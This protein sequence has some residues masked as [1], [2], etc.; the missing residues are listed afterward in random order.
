MI[1]LIFRIFLLL[2]LSLTALVTGA[3]TLTMHQQVRLVYGGEQASQN[4]N[5][6]LQ[7][8]AVNNG[9]NIYQLSLDVA[10]D[11][12]QSLSAISSDSLKI[13]FHFLNKKLSGS[14]AFR[15]FY[16][17]SLLMPDRLEIN[18][19]L[20]NGHQP[21]NVGDYWM[22]FDTGSIVIPKPFDSYLIF[23]VKIKKLDYSAQRLKKILAVTSLMNHYYGYD[24][25][26]QNLD[27]DISRRTGKLQPDVAD[28]FAS[29]QALIR[30]KGH[31]ARYDL[32]SK[33]HLETK[34][35][36]G[37]TVLFNKT[38]RLL[39]RMQSLTAQILRSKQDA[40]GKNREN[41]SRAFVDISI[42]ALSMA[43][44]YQ[45]YIA[46]SFNEF[47]ALADTNGFYQLGQIG[48][49]FDGSMLKGQ[50]TVSELICK[51]FIDAAA[52][53]NKQDNF[54]NALLLLDNA[55]LISDS[56]H[57]KLIEQWTCERQRAVEGMAVSY[58]KVAES[59]LLH[60]NDSIAE[61]YVLKAK[62][63]MNVYGKNDVGDPLPFFPEYGNQLFSLAR[64][65]IRQNRFDKA[66]YFLK[67]SSEAMPGN[68]TDDFK[69][70]CNT[71]VLHH[72]KV[73][74]G[75][76]Q[77]A[78]IYKAEI[79]L[80]KCRTVLDAF[81]DFYAN[82]DKIKQEVFK[83][84]DELYAGFLRAGDNSFKMKHVYAAAG[85]LF[86][87]DKLRKQFPGLPAE[88]WNEMANKS[89][90]PYVLSVANKAQL[91]IWAQRPQNALKIYRR[92]DSISN[93]FQIK[94]NQ[95]VTNALEKLKDKIGKTT[96]INLQ[97]Q[98]EK[99][100]RNAEI[101][102]D[103]HQIP[104]AESLYQKA[105]KLTEN[106]AGKNCFSPRKVKNAR[107]LYESV[108]SFSKQYHVFIQNLFDKGFSAVL[109][110]YAALDQS[111]Q[112]L[113]L[114][115]MQ[116]PYTDLFHFVENQHSATRAENVLHFF[117]EQKSYQKAFRYLRLLH[118]WNIEPKILNQYQK[119]IA[120][121]FAE[122]GIDISES[123]SDEP[124]LSDFW[125]NLEK[126]RK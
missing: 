58:L 114:G 70:S 119:L 125:L 67:Q 92:A 90:V 116:Y 9:L 29:S 18:L 17:D 12:R 10:C 76:M 78:K 23:D 7:I 42:H 41:F 62:E 11:F 37:F 44:N 52:I 50:E 106:G 34:D 49:Y 8:L 43:Q 89:L 46:N 71:V 115:K 93:V 95:T 48:K 88:A 83:R 35:P 102:L 122:K 39:T 66:F 73:F 82:S 26:L 105:W 64:V 98:V 19:S 61:S 16:L 91:E 126:F 4:I 31:E 40:D 13:Q 21:V 86:A 55:K 112:K 120:R 99:L 107:D 59:A 75:F 94:D 87:A 3:Q 72:L 57:V 68:L 117:L 38:I 124:W 108:T 51:R 24:K 60:A 27:A 2:G 123:K 15:D 22:L 28:V 32:V 118:R 103:A 14:T 104:E 121:G 100:Y 85:F 63:S 113:Q 30:L 53:E 25:L 110:Q 1:R 79:E 65:E 6:V 69:N 47:A 97:N 5:S 96:C 56:F 101:R 84:A 111:Y 33:L 81:P 77:E 54:V 109:P 74:D 20:G 80:Q 36:L 45:P